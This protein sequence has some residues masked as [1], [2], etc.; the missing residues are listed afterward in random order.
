MCVESRRVHASAPCRGG[1]S[2]VLGYCDACRPSEKGV[3]LQ[4]YEIRMEELI[5][6]EQAERERE[7]PKQPVE[8]DQAINYVN[9]IKDRFRASEHVYKSFLEILNQYRKAQKGIKEVYDQVRAAVLLWLQ[10][11]LPRLVCLWFA[12][13]LATASASV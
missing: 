13:P 5:Q 8:F 9:K 2:A 4:G 1:V 6:E 11:F 10:C 7:H 12:T 3:I